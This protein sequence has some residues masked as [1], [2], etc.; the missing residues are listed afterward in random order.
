ML[1]SSF[2]SFV[3]VNFGHLINECQEFCVHLNKKYRESYTNNTTTTIVLICLH[4]L[5]N[6]CTPPS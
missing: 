2:N 1:I 4:C 5:C 6:S 3:F